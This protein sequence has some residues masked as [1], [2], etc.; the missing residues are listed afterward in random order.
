MW[1]YDPVTGPGGP[2]YPAGQAALFFGGYLQKTEQHYRFMY[3]PSSRNHFT[4]EEVF[5]LYQSD[6]AIN[7][8]WPDDI[9]IDHFFVGYP[10]L[11]DRGDNV[12]R[13]KNVLVRKH[14]DSGDRVIVSDLTFTNHTG[15]PEY[16][17]AAEVPNVFFTNHLKREKVVGGNTLYNDGHVEW[18]DMRK[19]IAD[20]EHHEWDFNAGFNFSDIWF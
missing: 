15:T 2:H 20:W 19:M 18:L 9:E 16:V 12:P 11:V 1:W 6:T 10:Y 13:L 17:D 4:Y 5:L 14:T 7:P 8:D 3:C